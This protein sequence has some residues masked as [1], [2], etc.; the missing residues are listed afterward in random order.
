MILKKVSICLYLIMILIISGCSTEKND[1]VPVV[2]EN[3]V[4]NSID[5]YGYRTDR[6]FRYKENTDGEYYDFT[7]LTLGETEMQNFNYDFT[8]SNAKN[9]LGFNI[10]FSS[11][12]IIMQDMNREVPAKKWDIYT[13]PY[14][15]WLGE[16][17]WE[18]VP[19]CD[20]YILAVDELVSQGNMQ[21]K[22]PFFKIVNVDNKKEVV[23]YLERV[24]EGSFF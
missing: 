12:K 23:F 18:L 17:T 11:K 13:E 4:N 9:K 16:G 21:D 14:R 6:D 3:I 22:K 2:D 8:L 15:S 10:S 20:T 19:L 7:F 24:G 1:N 5:V